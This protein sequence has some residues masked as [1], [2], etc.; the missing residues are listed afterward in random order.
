MVKIHRYR[1]LSRGRNALCRV[2]IVKL[3]NSIEQNVPKTYFLRKNI[4]F[5]T[6]YLQFARRSLGKESN[7]SHVDIR[8]AKQ[9]VLLLWLRALRGTVDGTDIILSHN[10]QKSVSCTCG[11][12]LQYS[13]LR[14]LIVSSL[15]PIA[16]SLFRWSSIY[17]SAKRTLSSVRSQ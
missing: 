3:L 4:F 11:C 2:V 9:I 14:I 5:V 6:F 15:K 17:S 10:T 7:V 1:T 13:I 12:V 16:R 8:G